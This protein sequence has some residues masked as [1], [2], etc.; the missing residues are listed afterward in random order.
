MNRIV[1]AG[2]TGFFGRAALELLRARGHFALA[3]A[4]RPGADLRLDVEDRASLLAELRPGDI[5]L[6]TVGPFQDRTTTLLEAAIEVGCDVIDLSDSVAYAQRVR[7]L[8]PRIDT[9]GIR[10]LSSCSSVSAIS[11]ALVRSL[12]IE[13]PVRV[14]GFLAPAARYSASAGTGQSLLRSIGRPIQTLRDGRLHESPGWGEVWRAE[15]PS[16]LGRFAGRS[17]ESADCVWLPLAWPMLRA[18][19]YFVDARVPGLN[20][21]LAAAGR[22]PWLRWVIERQQ[23]AGRALARLFG[24]KTGCLGVAVADADGRAARAT[25]VPGDRGH[26]MA[27]TPAVLAVEAIVAGAFAHRGLVPP[28]AQVEPEALWRIL[29]ELR[30]ELVRDELVDARQPIC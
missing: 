18:V 19:D 29:R 16:E 5:V 26:R 17:F 2:G 7:A 10:V 25:L 27:V 8:A 21:L 28:H 22:R 13:R 4:R 1:V 12:A 14:T 23:T 9:A 20:H 11:A 24:S 3:A 30:V 6:D 15:L